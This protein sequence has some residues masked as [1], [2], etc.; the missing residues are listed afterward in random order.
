LE[1]PCQRWSDIRPGKLLS[2]SL[3]VVELAAVGVSL[4]EV[5][6]YQAR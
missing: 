3:I 6:R 2:V 1:S 4:L 5:V